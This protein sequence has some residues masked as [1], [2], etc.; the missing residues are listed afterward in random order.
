MFPWA[1]SFP[2]LS[3]LWSSPARCA[4]PAWRSPPRWSSVWAARSRPRPCCACPPRS[5]A[6]CANAPTRLWP[7]EIRRARSSNRQQWLCEEFIIRRPSLHFAHQIFTTTSFIVL[8]QMCVSESYAKLHTLGP[9]KQSLILIPVHLTGLFSKPNSNTLT[10]LQV[11]LQ[12]TQQL[13]VHVASLRHPQALLLGL[14]QPV[15]Q[16]AAVLVGAV[17]FPS[18]LLQLIYLLLQVAVSHLLHLRPQ[19]VNFILGGTHGNTR[20]WV[21]YH[22]PQKKST[23]FCTLIFRTLAPFIHICVCVFVAA[24]NLI[25]CSKSWASGENDFTLSQEE[26]PWEERSNLSAHLSLLNHP[27]QK[28]KKLVSGHVGRQLRRKSNLTHQK[29]SV[30]LCVC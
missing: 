11:L 16:D 22:S 6:R 13:S 26:F 3:P 17:Q 28:I 20:P 4:A 8:V 24:G 9:V 25:G 19:L 21:Q 14:S 23:G 1:I 18:Q 30:C 5:P 7:P 10:N 15:L 12:T 27:S 2:T 29:L